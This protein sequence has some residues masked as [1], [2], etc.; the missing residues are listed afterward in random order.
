MAGQTVSSFNSFELIGTPMKTWAKTYVNRTIYPA[1]FLNNY[2]FIASSQ[3]CMG[4]GK[5]QFSISCHSGM[6]EILLQVL[7]F[8]QID[9]NGTH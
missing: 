1:V 4:Q 2:Y 6:F 9:R 7:S 8:D 5:I 3:L